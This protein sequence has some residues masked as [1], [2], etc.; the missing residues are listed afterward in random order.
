MTTP[1][2][3]DAVK[4]TNI[5]ASPGPSRDGCFQGGAARCHCFDHNQHL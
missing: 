4:A 5:P 2:E 3:T 1:A